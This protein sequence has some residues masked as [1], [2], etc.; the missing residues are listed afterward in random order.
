MYCTFKNNICTICGRINK[1]GVTN[2][3]ANCRIQCIHLGPI[4]G[5]V[6]VKC[7]SCKG[8]ILIDYPSHF[9]KKL[10]RCLPTYSPENLTKWQERK[11]ESDIYH[12]C[13]G[14]TKFER[15]A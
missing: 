8:T 1:S 11:P 12:L 6:K 7:D 2:L 9:C 3:K 14:C 10:G 4:T 15:I 5:F 13:K